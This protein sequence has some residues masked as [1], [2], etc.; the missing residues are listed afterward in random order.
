MSGL[1]EMIVPAE[2]GQL[3]A[4]RDATRDT[5]LAAGVAEA[6]CERL[7]LAVGEA[8]M[9]VVQHGYRG[10]PGEITLEI[11]NNP[12]E[13]LFRLHDRAPPVNPSTLRGRA[14]DDL[15]PG[16]LGLRFIRE[17]M[18]RVD[19]LPPA[20][21]NGNLLE[22]RKRWRPRQGEES[23]QMNANERE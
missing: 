19:Y 8:A 12:G 11:L 6:L 14:L 21:G 5:L 13:L 10:A 7:V 4:L 1:L 23:P 3:K 2:A 9:N 18:D 22:M 20:E 15:R 17:L 16:G